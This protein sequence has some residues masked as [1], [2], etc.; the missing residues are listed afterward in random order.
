[1]AARLLCFWFCFAVLLEG[2]EL[3]LLSRRYVETGSASAR[4]ELLR[5]AEQHAAGSDGALARLALG[6]GDYQEK[7]YA[8]AAEQLA[9][10]ASRPGE[11]ADYA[12]YHRA[13]ALGAVEKYGEAASAIQ[14]FDRRFPDS[15]WVSP[16][17]A[18]RA[19]WLSLSGRAKE[20]LAIVAASPA[21]TAADWMLLGEVA[22]RAGEL[23]RAAEAYQ[24]VY[25]EFPTA[26]EA[27]EA[28]AALNSLRTRLGTRYP[29]ASPAQR[30][31]RADRL[32]AA[33]QYRTARA[34]YTTLSLR[35]QG[36]P[37]EQAAV[38]VAACDY[39][40]NVTARAYRALRA[41]A[42]TQ[43][44][45][46][47]EGVY[48]LAACAR[49]LRRADEVTRLIAELDEKHATSRWREEALFAAGNYFLLENGA[50]RY[51]P[52]YRAV[53]ENFPKGRY[54]ALA[55][56]KVAWR[57]YLDRSPEARK[58]L[59]DHL[60]SYPTSPQATAALFW[61]AR[62]AEERREHEAARALY[63]HL[64]TWYPHYYHTLLASERLQRLPPPAPN[65]VAPVTLLAA[66]PAPA[67]G[68]PKPAAS[69]VEAVLRR[70]R[71]LNEFGLAELAER[72]LRFRAESAR[73]AYHAGLELAQQAADRGSHYQ[74]IRYLKRYTPG[75]LALPFEAMPRRY[76]ELLF[77]LPWREQIEGYSEMRELDPY[78]VAALI[79]QESEFNPGAIS[80]AR[81]RGLM[82]IML[83]T[84]RR[85]GR[86]AGVTRVTASQL[87][88][89]ET[90]LKLGTLHL[91]RVLDQY[92]GR[93]EPALAGYNAGEHRAD[94]WLR[95]DPSSDPAEFV[96]SIPFTE[97]RGYVQAVLRNAAM[98][99]KLYGAAD[100]RR[101]HR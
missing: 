55:H 20:G 35:L 93:L 1:M 4:G 56:W 96:E 70:A 86:S 50:D 34:E 7:Q 73:L 39:H 53:F 83:A 90:S 45:A 21:T 12:V 24:K 66:L 74:A 76:W 75:Y 100:G 91:R 52:Y 40:L 72:E 78:L 51:V 46:A 33:E 71:L 81:A 60:R 63:T 79:R 15:P 18:R 9:L 94:E 59:E 49:R 42:V 6:I 65:A 27:N 10:A 28:Q 41:L 89:P 29:Q 5:Y 77:P 47:A 80:R 22:E 54:A 85:L 26:A 25:Y 23:A 43:P 38:R 67:A 99:R 64:T 14:G 17:S 36:L 69:E 92:D 44:E 3:T 97:T 19:E 101:S 88:L 37:R 87:Y 13:L 8:S 68:P 48:Y 30:L 95:W 32:A 2:S 84:G 31:G 58:L 11:L 61:I 62:L 98:Y 16:A 82:Q 57:A